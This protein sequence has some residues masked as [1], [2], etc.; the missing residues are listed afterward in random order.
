MKKD[1]NKTVL[2]KYY[3]ELNGV[4]IQ[5]YLFS[6]LEKRG[7]LTDEIKNSKNIEITF[8]VP[9]GGDWSNADIEIDDDN[10]INIIIQ[11]SHNK[12]ILDNKS[13]RKLP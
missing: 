2:S 13:N 11:T 5:E 8:K 4:D 6:L 3:F 7:E 10:P 12:Q 9:G 1:I